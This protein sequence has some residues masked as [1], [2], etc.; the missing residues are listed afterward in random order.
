MPHQ[1]V[2]DVAVA[3]VHSAWHRW[4]ATFAWAWLACVIWLACLPGL[5]QRAAAAPRPPTPPVTTEN[6][7]GAI[8]P[9]VATAPQAAGAD[10]AVTVEAGAALEQ[11]TGGHTRVVWV[12]DQ[13]PAGTDTLARGRRLKLLGLDS[14]DG[15][16][17]RPLRPGTSGY[18]KPLLTPDGAS[19]V[20]SDHSTGKVLVVDWETGQSRE[21]CPG[22]ALDTWADPVTS[23]QWVC[24]ATRAAPRADFVYRDVRRVRL[25]QPQ[26]EVPLWNQT[27]VGPD[28][29]QLSADGLFAAGEFPWP[30]AGV[31]DLSRGT[32]T[33]RATGCWAGL[34]PDNSGLA[35]VFDGPHRNWQLQGAS[36]DAP[37]KVPLDG[38][39]GLSGHEVFHPRW[40]NDPR[41][42][43]LSGPYLRRGKV[44][45]ISGG[46]PQVELHIG[47][48]APRFDR[49]E[50]WCQVTHNQRGDFHPDLW[51]EGGEQHRVP[52]EVSRR[53]GLAAA[54]LTAPS[55]TS[56]TFPPSEPGLEF[57]WRNS[58]VA[59]QVQP[60]G[61]SS[62]RL[63]VVEPRGFAHYDRHGALHLRGG[64]GDLGE[65]GRLAVAACQAA[66]AA[67]WTFA[68]TPE[69]VDCPA[70]APGAAAESPSGQPVGPA[71]GQA[72]ST[73]LLELTAQPGPPR[74]QVVQTGRRLELVWPAHGATPA[75]R[76]ELGELA[77]E[78]SELWS[79]AWEGGTLRVLRP[80]ATQAETIRGVPET[81]GP[82]QWD[83]GTLRLGSPEGPA[84]RGRVEQVRCVAGPL[85][86]E[87][88]DH[89][90]QAW[91]ADL[92]ARS[93]VPQVRA[94]VRV[95][96]T[97][98]VPTLAEIAPYR[99]ALVTHTV[100]VVEVLRGRPPGDRLQ[101][102]C[103]AVLDG[104]PLPGTRLPGATLAVGSEATLTLEPLAQ[105]PELESE[106]QLNDTPEFEL[107]VY[108]D[109]SPCEATAPSR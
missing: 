96:A 4:V 67:T 29:F 101:I 87:S 18:A 37:W 45:V 73:V 57:F 30:H 93:A 85:R 102:V 32:W 47:R 23:L 61:A 88:R 20:W 31:A 27:L 55:P 91:A 83:A 105:H 35:A 94:Q 68:L 103:W 38:G 9:L 25:D 1:V 89:W 49:I 51:V 66:N 109:V 36:G 107:P 84:W 106:R 74:W 41:F 53:S 54:D 21:L 22:F 5:P 46:G 59:N 98:A 16:G 12:Q 58:R 86:E 33:P 13:S 48:F 10:A 26:V 76:V 62:P 50:E 108:Y 39:A 6:L 90:R 75:G 72:A 17:E 2:L 92:A 95:V 28:N 52:A 19:V 81:L 99:R 44:N 42:V 24:V 56:P 82:V 3:P 78:R 69:P 80:G 79:L 71:T 100:E 70:V 104:E 15:R 7:P 60:A 97:T 77:A 40:S 43:V 64:W 63:C 11:F 34:A 14:R 65:A 8:A